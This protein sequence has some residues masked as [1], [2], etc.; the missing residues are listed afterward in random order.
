MKVANVTRAWCTAVVFSAVLAGCGAAATSTDT[1]SPDPAAPSGA[2][3]SQGATA[4]GE[5]TMTHPTTGLQG[6]ILHGAAASN[7]GMVA[8]GSSGMAAAWTSTDGVAWHPMEV[9]QA[10]RVRALHAVALDG[11]GV[12]FGAADPEPSRSWSPS[13]GSEPW[14]PVESTGID[15]RVNAVAISGDSWIA[16]GDLV[17]AETGTATAGAVWISDDGQHWERSTELPLRE[18]TISDIAVAG[19]MVVVGGFDVDGGKVW[20]STDGGQLERVDDGQFSATTVEGITHTD[21]GY[22]ALGRTLG[23]LRP[24]AFMSPDGVAWSRED[25]PTDAFPPDLQ[26]NDLTTFHGDPVAVGAGPDGGV[27]WTSTDGVSW[28]LHAPARE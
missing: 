8:V 23:D 4:S 12:A 2:N 24:V 7:D 26:I 28:T 15:G 1:Q 9:T 18:G 21:A 25:L 27:V 6:A 3:A 19:D 10:E 17:D 11:D 20:A 13:D 22:L 16:A 14:A 5:A